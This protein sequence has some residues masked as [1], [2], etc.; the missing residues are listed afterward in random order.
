M[1]SI[2]DPHTRAFPRVLSVI[3]HGAHDSSRRFSPGLSLFNC[4][5]ANC[6]LSIAHPGHTRIQMSTPFVSFDLFDNLRPSKPRGDPSTSSGPYHR[7][8]LIRPAQAA[9]TTRP[10]MHNAAADVLF[11]AFR[12]ANRPPFISR[13]LAAPSRQKISI[14]R[15]YFRLVFSGHCGRVQRRERRGQRPFCLRNRHGSNRGNTFTRAGSFVVCP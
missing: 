9:H 15:I 11:Q 3:P 2:L 7:E 4:Q 6:Q 8:S 14:F 1:L 10:Y 5:S 12:S 13:W